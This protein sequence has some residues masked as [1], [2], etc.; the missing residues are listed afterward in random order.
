M[1]LPPGKLFLVAAILFVAALAQA[2]TPSSP[3]TSGDRL[4]ASGPAGQ[5][6]AKLVSAKFSRQKLTS[7]R[8]HRTT[9]AGR[10]NQRTGT[11]ATADDWTLGNDGKVIYLT[12]DDG[13]QEEWTPK[14]LSVLARHHA[15]ATFF[16]LGREAAAHPE[17][18]EIERSLGHHVGNHTWDHPML[19]H[20]TPQRV[21][22][23]IFSGVKSKCFRPP[24]RDTNALVEAV[25]TANHQRQVLWDVDTNDWK[26]PGAA[27][28]ERAILRGAYP[29]A[30]ILMHDGGGNRA[31]TVAALERSLT[32]LTARG[33]T[34]RALPC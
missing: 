12:F 13:P 1:T 26:K 30:I 10:K 14:V 17:L 27:K 8:G 19:T 11:A 21:K 29:G 16:V 32:Q 6:P 15:K 3:Q 25:A 9:A 28:I 31:E 18:V 2:A 4:V 22:E 23:E 5:P 33:Y 20:L 24:Y 34:F 7:T